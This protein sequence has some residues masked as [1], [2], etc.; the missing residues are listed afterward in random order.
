MGPLEG[1]ACLLLRAAW[2]LLLIR[3]IVSWV[4]VFGWRPP[5]SGPLR[6]AH[7][8]LFDVTE[9]ILRP[10]RKLIPPAGAFD[11]SVAVAFVIIFVLQIA[12][13]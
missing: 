11:L 6:R 13:C 2:L 4:G 1:I 12:L 7:D 10:L 8:L 9:P 3:V 5:P